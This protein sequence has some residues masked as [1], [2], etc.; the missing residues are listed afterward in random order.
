[1]N[2]LIKLYREVAAV[3]PVAA[4]VVVVPDG[5]APADLKPASASTTLDINS[6]PP[7]KVESFIL[8][9]AYKDKSYLKGVDSQEKLLKMLDGAQELIG[10]RG[11]AI[12]KDGATQAEWDAYYESKGRPKTAA[13]YTFDGIDKADPK[14]LPK[15][16][17][18]MHKI[19][20]N[21]TEAKTLWGEVNVALGDYMKEKGLADQQQDIDFDKLAANTFGVERD[22]VL[23]RGKE[24]V[25]A[26]IS[27]TMKDA[28]KKLD[29]NAYVVLADILRNIDKKYISPDGAP[30]KGPTSIGMTPADVSSKARTLM[31]E[32]AKHNPMSQE[33][34]N[35]QKQIDDLYNTLRRK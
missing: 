19:G 10:K 28:A 17:A 9:D 6:P 20:L 13:E 8:P 18:A 16:Q 31:S 3:D 26:N 35:L 1:M 21:P 11:P 34:N 25:D 22:K 12:P 2:N 5:A 24:L 32:Q 23:A 33:Y 27:P 29:N 30:L 15:V 7:V 14:F 4:P